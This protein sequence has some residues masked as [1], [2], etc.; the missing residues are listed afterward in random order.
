MK[1][2]F[3]IFFA[4]MFVSLVAV[5]PIGAQTDTLT[6]DQAVSIAVA[7]H[8]TTN[9][10]A[11]AVEEAE[12]HLGIAKASWL[13]GVDAS[14]SY[15]RIGP[16]P[17]FDIPEFGHIKLFPEDNYSLVVN[18]RQLIYDFGRTNKNI[19]LAG[20]SK[21]MT[22]ENVNLVKQN[23]A[24]SVISTYYQILLL[25][26]SIRISDDELRNLNEHLDFILR[27]KETGSATDYE[28][29]STRVKISAIENQKVDYSAGLESLSAAMNALLGR[30]VERPVNV[31]VHLSIAAEEVTSD[32]MIDVALK[33]R[34]EIKLS[35]QREKLAGL[36]YDLAKSM[37]N[38]TLSA[39]ASGGGKNGYYPNLNAFKP[40]FTVGV[41]LNIPIFDGYREKNS[42]SIAKAGLE[43]SQFKSENVRRTVSTEVV[44]SRARVSSSSLKISQF[45]LQVRQAKRAYELAQ[46]SFQAGTITNL[47]LLD[48]EISLATSRLMLTKARID[49]ALE[50]SRLKM[51]LGESLF[52]TGSTASN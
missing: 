17:S 1:L 29:L 6:L 26:E 11:A 28:I 2:F 35:E 25:Q 30:P 3:K 32:S 13:P 22:A 45:E 49:Y 21:E 42:I 51:A 43:T 34:E 5:S 40:N 16:V 47:D 52:A 44:R 39:F 48:A 46:T 14:A 50:V 4:V 33:N 12:G 37:N 27:K 18:I 20:A 24:M 31:S 38:P 8:P 9:E 19:E 7:T 36:R 23:L 41:S 15:S 10:A